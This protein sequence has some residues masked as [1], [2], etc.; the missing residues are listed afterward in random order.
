MYWNT[1]THLPNI[2]FSSL[3]WKYSSLLD[4]SS[5]QCA[6]VA[7][8]PTVVALKVKASPLKS[9]PLAVARDEMAGLSLSA[10]GF[11]IIL[12][13]IVAGVGVVESSSSSSSASASTAKLSTAVMI[14]S[15]DTVHWIYNQQQ[16]WGMGMHGREWKICQ[17]CKCRK[18]VW[19][20]RLWPIKSI[21][22]I[23][24]P[25]IHRL[26]IRSK[27]PWCI[28]L[29]KMAST[30]PTGQETHISINFISSTMATKW[31]Y[32]MMVHQ[33]HT[34]CSPT[35]Q[36]FA[37]SQPRKNTHNPRL[38]HFLDTGRKQYL[39]LDERYLVLTTHSC[40]LLTHKS[41]V[42]K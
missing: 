21:M 16:S 5:I 9:I 28:S 36:C 12:S 38:I 17:H 39:D 11:F 29:L 34:L 23:E 1:T 13:A 26:I 3:L 33:C 25:G 6:K 7:R 4:I 42:R 35:N 10:L 14:Y 2:T 41:R 27:C 18:K 24:W 19:I 31:P 37:D 15:G 22:A 8:M 30:V 32:R 40:N 20:L